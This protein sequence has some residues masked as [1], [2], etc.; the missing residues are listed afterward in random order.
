MSRRT[1]GVILIAVGLVG[2]I[3]TAWAVAA[4]PAGTGLRFQTYGPGAGAAWS[5]HER[6]TC[7]PPVLPGQTVDVVLSDMGGMM[8]GGRMMRATATP[9][10]VPPGEV[11]FRVWN[12]GMMVHELVVLAL[13]A[14]GP[15]TRSV[16]SDGRVSEEGSFGEASRSCGEG[17]GEGIAPGAMGWVSLHLDPGRYEL[18]CNLP[19][20]YAAG[21]FAELDV[22]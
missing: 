11:S 3:G 10:T 19:G 6:P 9:S 22:S 15:G 21:M 13:P 7:S 1:L 18:I 12:S 16:G 4:G 2:L 5:A 20:H 8:M 14:D 17:A